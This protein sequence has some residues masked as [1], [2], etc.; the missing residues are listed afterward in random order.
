MS[1]SI[2]MATTSAVLQDYLT[3]FLVIAAGPEVQLHRKTR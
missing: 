3:A 2:L 1:W